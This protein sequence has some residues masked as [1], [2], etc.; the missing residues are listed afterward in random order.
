MNEVKLNSEWQVTSPNKEYWKLTANVLF[1]VFL[2]TAWWGLMTN[3]K[4]KS[5]SRDNSYLKAEN[6]CL[7]GQIEVYNENTLE[8]YAIEDNVL[9]AHLIDAE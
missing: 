7:K 2:F 4:Y 5:S 6:D 9:K 1:V 3:E 8:R